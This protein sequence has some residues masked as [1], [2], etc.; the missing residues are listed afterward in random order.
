MLDEETLLQTTRQYAKGSDSNDKSHTNN[1]VFNRCLSLLLTAKG[2]A[3]EISQ[4]FA[5][6]VF[7]RLTFKALSINPV[8]SNR[9]INRLDLSTTLRSAQDDSGV[10]LTAHNSSGG[11]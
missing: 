5:L 3:I 9:Q 4:F 1:E 8:P 10:I 7:S 6:S 11:R 2:Y